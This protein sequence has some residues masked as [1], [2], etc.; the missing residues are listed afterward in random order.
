MSADKKDLRLFT[1][2]EK[3]VLKLVVKAQGNKEIAQALRISPSTVKR[4]LENIP[5]KLQLK[6]RAGELP[7]MAIV[8]REKPRAAMK[9]GGKLL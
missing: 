5:R 7:T 4:H 9:A 2:Q 1:Q 6:N 3:K 8:D